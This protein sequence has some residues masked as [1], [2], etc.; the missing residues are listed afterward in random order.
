MGAASGG[1]VA[2]AWGG[3]ITLGHDAQRDVAEGRV[4][5]ED[6]DQAAL[7]ALRETFGEALVYVVRHTDE[8]APHW[9]FLVRNAR[10]GDGRAWRFNRSDLSE[11]QDK[12]AAHFH[13]FGWT[14]GRRK[15]DR[16][17]A[18]EPV[19]RWTHRTVSE[20]HQALLADRERAAEHWGLIQTAWEEAHQQRVAVWEASDRARAARDDAERL[21]SEAEREREK[22]AKLREEAEAARAK[23]EAKVAELAEA[24]ERIKKRLAKRQSE[25]ASIETALAEA[26]HHRQRH[27]AEIA[28]L[29]ERRAQLLRAIAR[30]EGRLAKVRAA[31]AEVM[32][33]EPDGGLPGLP[34]AR[35]RARRW[36]EAAAARAIEEKD[37][38]IHRLVVERDEA[39]RDLA[40]SRAEA[41]ELDRRWREAE[42]ARR[43][44]DEVRRF[45]RAVLDA[46]SGVVS[47]PHPASEI[48]A[49]VRK[50][51]A[52]PR[53]REAWAK[54]GLWWDD[55]R[56]AIRAANMT[57]KAA[58]TALYA[59][60][61]LGW[62]AVVC[63]PPEWARIVAAEAE[64]RG[65]VIDVQ[66]LDENGK[67][68]VLW[69]PPPSPSPRAEPDEPQS[70]VRQ[71]PQ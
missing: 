32:G 56:Q 71:K 59:A 47:A 22:A 23:A 15:E 28:A 65:I 35:A 49:R 64:R 8:A 29:E 37:D 17:A 18:A 19:S 16:I 7:A 42:A 67:P 41:L 60:R 51:L 62:N 38:E 40:E 55:K 57:R 24:E 52:N 39:R 44:A 10:P 4:R 54:A 48:G 27:A 3:I 50:I 58:A 66:A 25:L 43:E 9:H 53:E 21:R 70:E 36:A 31:V 20:L 46:A 5:I 69:S 63:Q 34:V 12:A 30:E 11:L 45:Y 68:T 6:V 33:E 1:S 2:P 61:Q 14:R 26:V 13:I